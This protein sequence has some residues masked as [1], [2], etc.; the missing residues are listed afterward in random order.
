MSGARLKAISVNHDNF[1]SISNKAKTTIEGLYGG[2]KFTYSYADETEAKKKLT[3]LN[4]RFGKKNVK[5][6]GNTI[7][8][9]HNMLG[10]S[11]DNLNID[12]RLL[13]PYSSETTALILD[14]VKEGGVPNV[15]LYTFDVYKSIVNCGANYETSIRFINQ[16]IVTELINRQ[17]AN[18]NVFG[19]QGFN[20]ITTVRRDLYI[21]IAKANGRTA[22]KTDTLDSFKKYLESIGIC[23]LYTSPSPRDA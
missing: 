13:T 4:K 14:G 1:V 6:E 5:R 8:I 21:A 16:P 3:I 7:T 15:D 23:L 9:N 19:E 2:F 11:Y 20:P 12:D 22:K 10:W 17:N 18:D